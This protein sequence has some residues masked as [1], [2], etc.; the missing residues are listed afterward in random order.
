MQENLTKQLNAGL[1]NNVIQR[2]IK[3]EW[4]QHLQLNEERIKKRQNK[5]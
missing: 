5:L 1:L 2:D 3:K 4:N